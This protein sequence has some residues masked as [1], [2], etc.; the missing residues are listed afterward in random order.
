[1]VAPEAKPLVI[2]I[3]GDEAGVSYRAA[4]QTDLESH[5]LVSKVINV[6]TTDTSDKTA[7]A[8]PAVDAARLIASGKA[9]RAL[10]I[11][12]TGLGV[13]IAANKVPGIRAV[14][15]HDSYSVERSVLSND[16]QVLCF[17]E[18]VIGLELAKRLAKEWV[19]YRFD[20]ESGS[21]SKV[22]DIME[23]E[24]EGLKQ[25]AK[26]FPQ[27]SPLS[28]HTDS[29]KRPLHTR[30]MADSMFT[31]SHPNGEVACN[32]ATAAHTNLK[33]QFRRVLK[34][35]ASDIELK[36]ADQEGD[37]AILACLEDPLKNSIRCA[38]IGTTNWPS[39]NEAT[40]RR[41][42]QH[43]SVCRDHDVQPFYIS[44]D[45]KRLYAKRID[46]LRAMIMFNGRE[47]ITCSPCAAKE[48]GVAPDSHRHIKWYD[49]GKEIVEEI[50]E[51]LYELVVDTEIYEVQG[52]GEG[53]RWALKD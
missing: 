33:T 46:Q 49:F 50:T 31:K 2:A 52:Y 36:N 29:H 18:R 39:D 28:V 13:A 24:K 30:A 14:T 45:M 1:M 25:G 6:G 51:K 26:E 37:T 20:P 53:A 5:K 3:G 41:I 16:A 15:A 27:A 4:I 7:Y 22:R 19:G 10:L 12:G 43:T 42:K 9:D 34:F 23:Y 48:G 38:R 11:C 32:S 47:Y 17:G 8:H 44:E 35:L 21:A 40:A